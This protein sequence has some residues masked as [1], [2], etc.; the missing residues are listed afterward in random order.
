MKNHAALG[1]ALYSEFITESE[2]AELLLH[3]RMYMPDRPRTGVRDRNA[4]VRFGSPKPFKDVLDGKIPAHLDWLCVK[5]AQAQH[6]HVKPDS[7]TINEYYP[8]QAIKPHID[9]A[10]AGP[11]ITVLSLASPATMVFTKQDEADIVVE[12]PPRSLVQ[13]RNEIRYEWQH[14]IKPVSALRYSMVFRCSE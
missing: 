12:L 10:Q 1:L 14:E 5:L 2:E 6:T 11:V 9:P 4:I 8:G 3:I 13:M 7:I